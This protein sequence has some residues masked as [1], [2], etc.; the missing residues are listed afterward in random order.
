M[1]GNNK[2]KFCE[3]INVENENAPTCGSDADEFLS[4]DQ[5]VSQPYIYNLFS[6][7]KDKI[8][9]CPFTSPLHSDATP[10]CIKYTWPL[11]FESND[12]DTQ[13]DGDDN[14]FVYF[15]YTTK[16]DEYGECRLFRFSTASK[17]VIQISRAEDQ[18]LSFCLNDGRGLYTAT[19]YQGNRKC[20]GIF[21]FQG[22]YPFS[23]HNIYEVEVPSADWQDDETMS[24]T[25]QLLYKE[26]FF[27]VSNFPYDDKSFGEIKRSF[28][29]ISIKFESKITIETV[30]AL[31]DLLITEMIFLG[32]TL[33]CI[34]STSPFP[35]FGKDIQKVYSYCF[36]TNKLSLLTTACG[37]CNLSG[38]ENVLI[39][40]LQGLDV[41]KCGLVWNKLDETHQRILDT[42]NCTDFSGVVFDG[43][44]LA[45]TEWNSYGYD[46]DEESIS[47]FHLPS[48][49]VTHIEKVFDDL[50]QL[51]LHGKYLFVYSNRF[52][53]EFGYFDLSAL[54]QVYIPIMTHGKGI[55]DYLRDVGQA[56]EQSE[57]KCYEQTRQQRKDQEFMG[58]FLEKIKSYPIILQADPKSNFKKGTI[59]N[60]LRK[61]TIVLQ[62]QFSSNDI[63]YFDKDA[64]GKTL[65]VVDDSNSA[66]LLE[67]RRLIDT[68]SNNII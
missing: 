30:P 5:S 68:F 15:L 47:L 25:P 64:L 62:I 42:K 22:R 49:E 32:N 54:Q 66:K 52:E 16:D 50:I 35:Y 17:R 58:K 29:K 46:G 60:C 53:V 14:C 11:Y 33:I 55:L 12:I 56:E 67:L 2:S 37:C 34:D 63:R 8:D 27:Y 10:A 38:K 65:F 31:N 6:S 40:E 21:L 57:K 24:L 43:F 1:K 13:D 19:W 7:Q 4:W 18:V 61:K 45:A 48:G 51:T 26:G 39:F 41:E 9:I 28:L 44:R 23:V 36:C 3:E 20:W 59:I